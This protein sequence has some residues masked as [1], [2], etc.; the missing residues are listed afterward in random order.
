MGDTIM[1]NFKNEVQQVHIGFNKIS[2]E[3]MST[4]V[5]EKEFPSENQYFKFK[6][7]KYNPHRFEYVGDHDTGRL[8]E[9]MDIKP[10]IYELQV[11]GLCADKIEKEYPAHKQL[12]IYS[13]L[14]GSL[15]A[16]GTL[17]EEDSGVEEFLDMQEYIER[18]RKNNTLYKKSRIN[19]ETEEYISEDQ[20]KSTV[21]AQLAGGLRSIIFKGE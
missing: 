2:G 21:D 9:R 12:N 17:T 18:S 19:S 3:R 1:S 6:S 20:R 10:K 8:V 14:F 16:N 15:I 4:V 11:N 5:S 7:L 13:K